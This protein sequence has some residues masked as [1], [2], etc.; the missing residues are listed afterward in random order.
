MT[1]KRDNL[2]DKAIKEACKTR[3]KYMAKEAK[4]AN[5]RRKMEKKIVKLHIIERNSK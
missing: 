1:K 2:I 5:F 3:L 4:Y